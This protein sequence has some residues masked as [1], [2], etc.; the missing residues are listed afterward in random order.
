MCFSIRDAQLYRANAPER[1][2]GGIVVAEKLQVLESLRESFHRLLH[3]TIFA[4]EAA[5]FQYSIV[6][7]SVAS[8]RERENR[9]WEECVM[10]WSFGRAGMMRT[11]LSYGTKSFVVEGRL[12][13]YNSVLILVRT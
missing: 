2:D 3:R 8:R 9:L 4:T 12:G 10:D 5:R 13:H 7:I 6:V 1:V 11:D